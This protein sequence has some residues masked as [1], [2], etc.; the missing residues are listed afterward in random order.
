LQSEREPP[1]LPFLA[2]VIPEFADHTEKMA[3]LYVTEYLVNSGW[4]AARTAG[5]L[6][7][8][9]HGNTVLMGKYQGA[10]FSPLKF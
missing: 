2:P 4:Y 5:R 6:Q 9:V 8:T 3:Y 1:E 10:I 7:F